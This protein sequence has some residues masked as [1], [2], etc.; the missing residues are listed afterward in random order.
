MKKEFYFFVAFTS[1]LCSCG[2]WQP[3]HWVL[4]RNVAEEREWKEGLRF[5]TRWEP[6]SAFGTKEQ[7]EKTMDEFFVQSKDSKALGEVRLYPVGG[8]EITLRCVPDAVDPR[9]K[10]SEGDQKILV[11]RPQGK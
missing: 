10:G 9:R 4:W 8:R 11:W 1:V 3:A 6:I 2:D 7:C 5:P